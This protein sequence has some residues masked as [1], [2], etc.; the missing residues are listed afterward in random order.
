[1]L[2]EGYETH[3]LQRLAEAAG[4]LPDLQKNPE[5]KIFWQRIA[6]TW[7]TSLR[8]TGQRFKKSDAEKFVQQVRG[9][10]QW[11]KERLRS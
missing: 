2:P 10:A 5:L 7:S 8:Y 6:R 3:D 1:M 4:I 11:L 9:V